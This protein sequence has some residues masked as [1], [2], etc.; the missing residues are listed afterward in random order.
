MAPKKPHDYQT[1][2]VAHS[3]ASPL[4]SHLAMEPFATREALPPLEGID[5]NV[6]ASSVE[7]YERWDGMS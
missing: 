2:P 1:Q 4:L 6:D 5:P 7:E 3:E